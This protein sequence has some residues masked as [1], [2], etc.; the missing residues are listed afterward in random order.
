MKDE[1]CKRGAR[2]VRTWAGGGSRPPSFPVASLFPHPS[3]LIPL[4]LIP[5]GGPVADL[6]V[7]A[8]PLAAGCGFDRFVCVG[9]GRLLGR[10]EDPPAWGFD[11]GALTASC[12]GKGVGL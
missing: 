3:Y 6:G 4:I 2:D 7:G 10:G 9:R 8:A 11:R 12:A 1:G 5:H